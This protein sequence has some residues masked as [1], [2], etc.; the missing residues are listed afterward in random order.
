MSEA[1]RAAAV[2]AG[3][4]DLDCLRLVP[5]S[6]EAPA[7]QMAQLRR[8]KPDWFYDA[9]AFDARTASMQQVNARLAEMQRAEAVRQSE[10]ATRR[11]IERLQQDRAAADARRDMLRADALRMRE[12]QE[13]SAQHRVSGT[14]RP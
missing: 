3:L 2:A 6:R 4:I 14:R 5:F 13:R 11:T 7:E 12:A 1:L 9:P 10:A 8:E